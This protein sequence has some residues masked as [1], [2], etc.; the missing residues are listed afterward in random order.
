MTLTR[1]IIWST[2]FH[3]YSNSFYSRSLAHFFSVSRFTFI[4]RPRWKAARGGDV[5][6][7]VLRARVLD[8]LHEG[9]EARA[10]SEGA[11]WKRGSGRCGG[12]GKERSTER[13]GAVVGREMQVRAVKWRSGENVLEIQRSFACWGFWGTW[14]GL[15]KQ[16]NKNTNA[17]KH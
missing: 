9:D 16:T 3:I 10:H 12:L 2:A 6:V 11:R 13:R 7:L 15:D 1:E 8:L 5:V 17:V 4:R 14:K